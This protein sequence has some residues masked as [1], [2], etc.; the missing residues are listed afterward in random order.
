MKSVLDVTVSAFRN[1]ASVEPKDVRLLTW[2]TSNKYAKKVDRIRTVQ[3]K[4]IRDKWKAQLPAITP[5][6]RFSKRGNDFLIEHSGL[7]QADIDL[8]HNQ[9]LKNFYDLK[10]QLTELPEVAY[11]GLSVSGQGFWIL[12]PIAYPD[13]HEQHFEALQEDLKNLNINIDPTPDV[14]RLRGYSYDREAYFNHHAEVY[15]RCVEHSHNSKNVY[16]TSGSNIEKVE[17]CIEIIEA[18]QIDITGTYQEWFAVGCALAHE[19]GEA[20]RAYYHRVSQYYPGYSFKET[21]K[22]FDGL[23]GGEGITI[24]TF[25]AIC[26]EYGVE[27]REVLYD[28]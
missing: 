3:D 19:F 6:G 16:D 23:I 25:F 13:K 22:Q 26:K 1:Y 18:E 7:L 14:S 24:A 5:S 17:A 10:K 20:G 8:H 11:C 4:K 28:D 27:F 2:L 15:T 21:D 9:H 12:V